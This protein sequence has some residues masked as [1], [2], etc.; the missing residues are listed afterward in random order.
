MSVL[1]KV[2]IVLSV[3]I[4][5]FFGL[6]G[7]VYL[8]LRTPEV[9]VPDITGKDRFAAE[10]TLESA[11]LKIHVRSTKPSLDQKPDTVLNQVPEP[12]QVV[13]SGI[14][15]AVQISRAPKEGENVSSSTEEKPQEANKAAEN[16]N[17]NANQNSTATN[18]NQ[19]QNQNK[20]KN[21]NKNSNNS[22]NKNASNSNNAN[23]ANRNANNRN[24]NT[25]NRNANTSNGNRTTNTTTPNANRSNVNANKRAPATTSPGA[26]KGT[27]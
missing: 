2:G 16:N 18:Q 8:S 9:K 7:T 25:A 27:P 26:N 14:E 11:G 23:N 20:P 12:G 13:K 4:F 19:N 6:L 10:S 21:K 5:F 24:A 1:R 15:V 17:A 22:N 3:I